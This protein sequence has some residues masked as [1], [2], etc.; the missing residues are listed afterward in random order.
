MVI[1]IIHEVIY[2]SPDDL[3]ELSLKP[4]HKVLICFASLYLAEKSG[5]KVGVLLVFVENLF[6]RLFTWKFCSECFGDKQMFDMSK[7]AKLNATMKIR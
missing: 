2:S 1:N 4:E 3:F 5:E 7:R 6:V